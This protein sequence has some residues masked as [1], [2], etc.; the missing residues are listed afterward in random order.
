[1]RPAPLPAVVGKGLVGLGHTVS[2]F[3]LFDRSASSGGGVHQFRG[4]PVDHRFFRTGAGEADQPAKGQGLAPGRP[5]LDRDLVGRASHAAAFD[6]DKG[7]DALDRLFEDLDR[8]LFGSF[9]DLIHRAVKNPLGGAA[10][11]VPHQTVGKLRHQTAV[12]LRIGQYRTLGNL[13]TP[14]HS[15]LDWLNAKKL[16]YP[17]LFF[18]RTDRLYTPPGRR[19]RPQSSASFFVRNDPPPSSKKDNRP[20]ALR[21]LAYEP[22]NF[23]RL[24][25]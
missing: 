13:S 10:F 22:V 6:L 18:G 20:A 17:R 12:V 8:V 2:V 19:Y 9:G 7:L 14:R 21:N 3:P 24:R 16:A 15:L 23:A 1:M 5:D 11:T 4:Q 25:V